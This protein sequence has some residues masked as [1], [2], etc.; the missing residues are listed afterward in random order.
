M[1]SNSLSPSFAICAR[2]ERCEM[3]KTNTSRTIGP[4]SNPFSKYS[5]SFAHTTSHPPIHSSMHQQS[6]ITIANMIWMLQSKQETFT[7]NEGERNKWE[8]IRFFGFVLFC[9][10][11]H[12][13]LNHSLESRTVKS[14]DAISIDKIANFMSTFDSI[15]QMGWLCCI[16]KS[17]Q[18][19]SRMQR[20][21]DVHSAIHTREAKQHE[22]T[23]QQ[24]KQQLC[25]MCAHLI[26]GQSDLYWKTKRH[27]GPLLHPIAC[28]E[29]ATLFFFI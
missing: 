27:W 2:R 6:R 19:C 24:Q 4:T 23:M 13:N 16:W 3:W 10:F 17:P 21:F 25:S 18:R 7:M 11:L 26:S 28:I 12:Y 29:S 9:S 22:E 8:N 14:D 20:L 15:L 5:T 1:Q